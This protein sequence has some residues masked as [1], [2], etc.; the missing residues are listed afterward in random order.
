MAET[1]RVAVLIDGDNIR[2]KIAKEILAE[3]A[4]HGT[5]SIKRG[6]GN[7]ASAYLSGGKTKL[8]RHAIQPVAHCR[9]VQSLALTSRNRRR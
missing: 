8:A 1:T 4:K 9:C 5:L 3:T 2:S 6:Y 7:W